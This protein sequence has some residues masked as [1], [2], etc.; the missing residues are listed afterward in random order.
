MVTFEDFT[1]VVRK[2]LTDQHANNM[3]SRTRLILIPAKVTLAWDF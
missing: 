1:Q 3:D 2:R